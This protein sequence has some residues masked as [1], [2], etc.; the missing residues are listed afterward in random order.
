MYDIP[1]E[2]KP[3]VSTTPSYYGCSFLVTNIV[4]GRR[5]SLLPEAQ[6]LDGDGIT[7]LVNELHN[8]VGM[9]R[10]GSVTRW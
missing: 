6:S 2:K 4:A 8:L 10:H 9:R 1:I 7:C 5:E 3:K